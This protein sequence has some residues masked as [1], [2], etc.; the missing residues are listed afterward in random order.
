MND[1]LVASVDKA[2]MAISSQVSLLCARLNRVH[3]ERRGR[4][5]LSGV[6]GRLWYVEFVGG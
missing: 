5:H 3:H 6:L 1:S 4:D 2:A